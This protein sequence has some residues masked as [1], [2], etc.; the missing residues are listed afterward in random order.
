MIALEQNYCSICTSITST[1]DTCYLQ[2]WHDYHLTIGFN[3]F[4]VYGNNTKVPTLLNSRDTTFIET[5]DFNN[6]PSRCL[7]RYGNQSTWIAFFDYLQFCVLKNCSNI[8]D[9]LK[10]YEQYGALAVCGYGFNVNDKNSNRKTLLD[11][12]VQR[13]INS[14]L[15]RMIVRP[16]RVSHMNDG[17]VEFYK[18]DYYGVDEEHQYFVINNYINTNRVIQLNCYDSFI[19]LDAHFQ[20]VKTRFVLD[21]DILMLLAK[22]NIFYPSNFDPISYLIYN[23]DLV[24]INTDIV[25]AVIHWYRYG[26]KEERPYSPKI[27]FNWKNYIAR[28]KDL[29]KAGILTFALAIQHYA[30]HGRKEGRI[31][32]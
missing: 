3:H 6:I 7:H 17:Y 20:I 1:D 18:N 10:N 31:C 8:K 2:E 4:Y 28:Y 11:N 12:N 30:N 24:N 5:T 21:L 26:K 27:V 16:D 29:H 22:Y 19:T 9:L 14:H 25:W 15:T 23:L 32:T 13:E